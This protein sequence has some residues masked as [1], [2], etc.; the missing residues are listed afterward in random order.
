MIVILPSAVVIAGLIFLFRIQLLSLV[1]DWL[2]VQDTLE[3]ADIIHVISGHD[4]RSDYAIELY[5]KGYGKVLFFTG[6]WCETIQGNHAERG[7][8]LAIERGISAQAVATDGTQVISTYQE[9]ERLKAFV[10]QSPTPYSSIIVVSDPFHMRRARWTY[11]RIFGDQIK[12]QMTPIP[13]ELTPF[14]HDWWNDDASKQYVISE[15]LKF[16]Y[17]IIRYE[18]SGGLIKKWLVSLDRE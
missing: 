15:Y 8:Q 2:I 10:D 6:G 5:Q 13:F 16:G 11:R 3:P 7:K 14:K 17:Y 12:I 1:G 18:Y 9:A 4:Y